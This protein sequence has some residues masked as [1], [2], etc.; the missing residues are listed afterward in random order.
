M[1]E[2]SEWIQC[3]RCARYVRAS[4]ERCPFCER[5]RRACMA[6]RPAAA[7]IAAM[8]SLAPV[9]SSAESHDRSQRS[10]QSGMLPAYGAPPPRDL[11]APQPST[12]DVQVEQLQI[13]AQVQGRSVQ[14]MHAAVRRSPE[15]VRACFGLMPSR[16]HGV[17]QYAV[18]LRLHSDAR[19]PIAV[20]V[21]AV[22]SRADADASARCIRSQLEQVSWPRPGA[23]VA[24]L[25]WSYRVQLRDRDPRR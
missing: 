14:S 11:L 9:Q 10:A 6:T 24:V 18:Q 2:Q 15:R 12:Y 21:R 13:E 8:A 19:T 22:P 7:V 23:G 4:D 1:N 5:D 25:R 3:A 16:T 17:L 20:T